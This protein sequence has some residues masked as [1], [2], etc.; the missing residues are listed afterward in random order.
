MA[1]K[2]VLVPQDMY[3]S[4][5][6]GPEDTVAH[7]RAELDST[8]HD[9]TKSVAE[10]NLLYSKRLFDFMKL[11]KEAMERPVKVEVTNAPSASEAPPPTAS[12]VPA[13]EPLDAPHTPSPRAARKRARKAR[14]PLAGNV[15][16]LLRIID[17]DRD[18]FGVDAKGR[19]LNFNGRLVANSSIVD[20]VKHLLDPQPFAP[21]PPGTKEVK[22][23]LLTRADTRKY[24]HGEN[25][26]EGAGAV[27][28][29][30]PSLWS[31]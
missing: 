31:F 6:G 27:K 30:R 15:N 3:H 19:V 1:R 23:R 21:D 2:F 18:H 20:V 4:L 16:Q 24:V 10:K 5:L 25:V 13:Q 29:F 9:P 14:T 22:A 11:R 26:Q 8:L 7:A 28:R 17:A 12:G